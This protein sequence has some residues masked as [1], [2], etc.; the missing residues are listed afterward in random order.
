MCHPEHREGFPRSFLSARPDSWEGV[1]RVA[2]GGISL[3][4]F[5]TSAGRRNFKASPAGAERALSTTVLTRTA[6]A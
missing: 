1:A 3:I 4:Q 5:D 2:A 6:K